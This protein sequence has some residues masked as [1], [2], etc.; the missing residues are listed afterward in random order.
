[1][2]QGAGVAHKPAAG[3]ASSLDPGDPADP[4]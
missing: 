2:V 1:M 3:T 4:P